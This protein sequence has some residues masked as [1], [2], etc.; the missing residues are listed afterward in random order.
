MTS[1]QS[2]SLDNDVR[3]RDVTE[4]DLPILFAHQRDPEGN[5]MAAFTAK[6]PSDY[7]EFAERWARRFS[8]ETAIMKVVLV[9]GQVAGHIVCVGASVP[10]EV[11]YWI[12]RPYWGRGVATRALALLLKQVSTRPLQAHVAKDNIASRRVLEKCGFR[13]CGETKDFANARGKEIEEFVL[14]LN[15]NEGDKAT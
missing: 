14:R 2:S 7:T 8:D 12:D 1:Q 3:L 10:K 5:Y 15:A 11:G 4:A 6:D 13:I 9:D